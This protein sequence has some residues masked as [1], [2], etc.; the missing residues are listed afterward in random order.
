VVAG[1]DRELA[2]DVMAGVGNPEA[3]R[4]LRTILSDVSVASRTTY[5]RMIQSAVL[6]G[7][8]DPQTVELYS[9]L[10]ASEPSENQVAAMAM[11]GH[12]GAVAAATDD[13]D[14]AAGVARTLDDAMGSALNGDS[15]RDVLRA[16]GNLATPAAE[17]LAEPYLDHEDPWTRSAAIRALRNV[18]TE[19]A[20]EALWEGMNDSEE[21]VRTQALRGLSRGGF[22]SS[23][24]DR[25]LAQIAL[26]VG[27]AEAVILL[28]ASGRLEPSDR[29]RVLLALSRL[30]ALSASTGERIQSLLPRE[31]LARR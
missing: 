25:M 15:R 9:N 1:S 20:R 3:H 17:A 7:I 23:D 27:D 12:L 21:F 31:E 26:G 18:Q 14:T 16:V 29:L 5:H 13:S 19:S 2:M 28:D 8:H 24:L 4:A 30:D 6:I 11:L 22:A 10:T